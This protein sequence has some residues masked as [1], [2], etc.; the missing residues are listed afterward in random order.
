MFTELD[1]LAYVV[2]SIENDCS[3]IPVGAFRLTATHELRYNDTF[4]GLHMTQANLL[5]NY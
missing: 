5:E 4:E 1:R 2:R 3:L